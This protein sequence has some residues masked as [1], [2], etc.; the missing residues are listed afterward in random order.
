MYFWDKH[1]TITS[2]YELL[3][4]K[5]CDQYELTQMEYDIIM[6]LHNNPHHN[7]AAEIVRIRKSTK[8]HVSSSLKK[9]ENKVKIIKN[10]LKLSFWMMRHLSWTQD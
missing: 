6:F 2:Y 4:G 3:S 8:S 5:V 7:T 9:L 10:I 1:K